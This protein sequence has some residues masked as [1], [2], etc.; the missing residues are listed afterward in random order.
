LATLGSFLREAVD[1]GATLLLT[2][3]PGVGKT[4]LLVAAAEMA[5]RDG[6]RVIHGGG[7]EY[8]TDVSLVGHDRG[9]R[10]AYRMALD[11]PQRV[12]R[13]AV[14]NVIP[15]V[16]QFERMGAGPSLG[17]WPWFLLAQPAPFPERLVAAEPEHFLRF[18]GGVVGVGA[19]SAAQHDAG[20]ALHPGGGHRDIGETP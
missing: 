20:R 14:L 13:L 16:A 11:Y 5:A 3:E 4:A 19:R 9:G 7:V 6:V 2:G 10:V 17:Y 12:D 15:T 8:E 1:D 18:I